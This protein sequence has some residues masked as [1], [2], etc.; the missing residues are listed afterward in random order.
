VEVEEGHRVVK[1]RVGVVSDLTSDVRLRLAAQVLDRQQQLAYARRLVDLNPN[2]ASA[3]QGLLGQLGEAEGLDLLRSRLGA[4]P[5]LVEWHR[6]YQTT[7]EKL[8]PEEDLRPTY[9]QLVA[10]TGQHPDAL[11][12][13]ARLSDQDPVEADRLLHQAAAAEPP[14]VYGLHALGYAALDQGQFDEAVRWT[15][16]AAERAPDNRTLKDGYRQALLAAGQYDALL[17][18]LRAQKTRPGQT[19][20]VVVDEIRVWG[21][22][23]DEAQAQALI[24]QA[25]K[26]AADPND[27]A[28]GKEVQASLDM[29]LSCA[30][31][32]AA[33]FLDV[34]PQVK[35]LSGF[36]PALLRGKLGE[37]AGLVDDKSDR[38]LVQRA[39]LYLAA[40]KAGDGKLADEQWAPLLTG[41][42]KAHGSLGRLGE[43]LAG[44][45]KPDAGRIR[46][47]SIPP[48]QKRVLLVVVAR[49]YPETAKELLPLARK[50]DFSPDPT[51]L[52]LRKV[53]E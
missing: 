5:I 18:L 20:P 21:L 41:L 49:R 12:L 42:D 23:G 35:G 9:R 8:H 27:Q 15:R 2:D 26:S 4:R 36:E 11:Y 1:T 3:L 34:A 40:L 43:V 46:L 50:L 30:R 16:R 47:L 45:Q 19:L 28:S 22:K 37:A 24:A 38:A 53:L 25:V 17:E 33:K 39:L 52:C 48:E 7:M 10:E 14:S 51:S 31:R 13:L 32:D 29:V 6:A 44:R